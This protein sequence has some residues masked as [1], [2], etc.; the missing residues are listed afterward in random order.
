MKVV[1]DAKHDK[2]WTGAVFECQHG[3]H[4]CNTNKLQACA[5]SVAGSS[6]SAFSFLNCME[7]KQ[8]HIE[9]AQDCATK[10]KL[11]FGAIKKCFTGQT[12]DALQWKAAITTADEYKRSTFDCVPWVT[13]DSHHLHCPNGYDL[14]RPLCE[15]LNQRINFMKNGPRKTAQRNAVATA[16]DKANVD[17]WEKAEEED[18]IPTPKQPCLN[19]HWSWNSKTEVPDGWSGKGIEKYLGKLCT[20][21][22]GMLSFTFVSG[23]RSALLKCPYVDSCPYLFA[24]IMYV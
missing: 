5:I 15:H 17:Q 12:G 23:A 14:I 24:C 13:L 20:C 21:H 2:P 6:H 1:E 4:G 7:L 16:C 3:P 11:D 22:D 9:S 19:G 18:A 10:C 8:G